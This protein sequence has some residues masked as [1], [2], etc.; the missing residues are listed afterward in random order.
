MIQFIKRVKTVITVQKVLRYK[1][2]SMRIFIER[3]N[4]KKHSALNFA[5]F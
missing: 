5:S 2:T 3:S 1:L 4:E